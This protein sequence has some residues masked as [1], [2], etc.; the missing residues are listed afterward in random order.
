LIINLACIT[1]G[2]VQVDA[3]GKLHQTTSTGWEGL[4]DGQPKPRGCL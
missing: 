1:L 3:E 4:N 2:F